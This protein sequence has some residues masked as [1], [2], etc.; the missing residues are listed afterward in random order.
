MPIT[1]AWTT[2]GS[3]D[4]NVSAMRLA[5]LP[6]VGVFVYAVG[7]TFVPEGHTALKFITELGAFGFLS[8]FCWY[9]ITKAVPGMQEMFRQEAQR[10]REHFSQEAREARQHQSDV[11]QQMAASH[12]RAA[13]KN[14]EVLDRVIRQCSARGP[15]RRE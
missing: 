11:I 7:E 4:G 6:A 2:G 10:D 13:E 14:R 9:G 8:W 12:E 3:W 5:T 15:E 1:T